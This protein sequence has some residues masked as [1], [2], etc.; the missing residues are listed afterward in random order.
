MENASNALLIAGAVLIGV[1]ILSVGVYLIS[2]FQN[3]S[4]QIN[5]QIEQNKIEAFNKEFTKYMGLENIR[6]HQIVSVA[7]LARQNNK[8]NYDEVLIKGDSPYYITVIVQ[9]KSG[10]ATVTDNQFEVN[11]SD[12]SNQA[13]EQKMIEFIKN[14]DVKE[15]TNPTEKKIIPVYFKCT[16]VAFNQ[17]T[18]MV[19]RIKFEQLP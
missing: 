3:S 18:K 12:D 9:T 11:T 14:Y 4:S 6:A 17:H 15:N 5:N 7:N 13:F 16:E 8:R 10:A 19:E 2:S 1:M